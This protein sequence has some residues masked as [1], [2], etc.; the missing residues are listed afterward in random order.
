MILRAKLVWLP[1]PKASG[2]G[3]SLGAVKEPRTG[4]WP[5][6]SH[7]HVE[8]L[9]GSIGLFVCNKPGWAAPVE[10]VI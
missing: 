4:V 7:S 5:S 9:T 1:E 6:I 8:I 3:S 10:A 2:I